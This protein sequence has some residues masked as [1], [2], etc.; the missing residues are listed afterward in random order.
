MTLSLLVAATPNTPFL[1]EMV[2]SSTVVTEHN[3]LYKKRL[4]AFLV[5]SNVSQG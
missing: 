1:F 5:I 3:D 4:A 2:S